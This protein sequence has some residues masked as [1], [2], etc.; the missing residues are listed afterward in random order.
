[1]V[2]PDPASPT[3]IKARPEVEALTPYVAPLEGRRTLLR[4]DFN[5][6]TIGPSPRVIE[7]IRRLPA[8][9]YATYPEYAGQ[10]RSYAVDFKLRDGEVLAYKDWRATRTSN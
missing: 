10:F 2:G 6:S 1:M 5:E 3:M 9:A 7:A 8:E 4:L